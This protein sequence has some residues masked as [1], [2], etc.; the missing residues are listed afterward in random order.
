[1]QALWTAASGLLSQQRRINAISNNLANVDTVGYKS[2]S[3]SFQDLLYRQF[4]Q[5]QMPTMAQTNPATLTRLSPLGLQLGSGVANTGPENDFSNGAMKV[6]SQPLDFAIQ[7]NSF[8]AVQVPD[9]TGK[10][11][12]A[13]TRNGHFQ[14]AEAPDGKQYLA[15]D[16]GYKV[17]DANG[18]PIDLTG[19]NPASIRVYPDGTLESG[20]KGQLTNLGQVGLFYFGDPETALRPAGNNVFAAVAGTP[21]PMSQLLAVTPQDTQNLGTIHQGFLEQSNV[22]TIQQMTDLIQTQHAF[23]LDA[24]AITTADQMMAIANNL[25]N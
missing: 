8:F 10:T 12:L 1:M 11:T 20:Q 21:A 16:Q 19:I 14:I 25:R 3:V 22:D 9:G 17:T 6:T 18:Q 15:T 24:K 4:D 2:Q 23:E 5:K 13:Y 7:G